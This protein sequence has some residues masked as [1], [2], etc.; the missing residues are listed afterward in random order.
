MLDELFKENRKKFG[1]DEAWK[2]QWSIVDGLRRQ[3]EGY[4]ESVERTLR[5]KEL[6]CSNFGEFLYLHLV[7]SRIIS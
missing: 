2:L 7:P 1:D 6:R 3:I 4:Q 5:K